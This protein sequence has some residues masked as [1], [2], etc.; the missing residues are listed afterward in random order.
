MDV[1]VIVENKL[2]ETWLCPICADPLCPS[3]HGEVCPVGWLRKLEQGE[4]AE[5]ERLFGQ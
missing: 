4:L 1:G 2:G 5:L 3:T